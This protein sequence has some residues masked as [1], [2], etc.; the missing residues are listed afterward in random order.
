[1][2]ILSIFPLLA[3]PAVFY[4]MF[5]AP[6]GGVKVNTWLAEPAF[7]LP[8]SGGGQW[9]VTHG[10]LFTLFA[11]LCLFVEIIKSVRPTTAGLIDNSLSVLVFVVCLIL[12]LLVPGFGTTEFF[13]ILLM[14]ILD[15]MAGAVV[16]VTAARRSVEID[17]SVH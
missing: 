16:M 3:I 1:M 8:M 6:Q 15:F 7:S 9:V 17:R 13:L 10:H 5:A 14:S 11:I 4:A 2:G 12:F